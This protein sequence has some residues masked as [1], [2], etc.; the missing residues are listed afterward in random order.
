MPKTFIHWLLYAWLLLPNFALLFETP[1]NVWQGAGLL[2]I[3]IALV[4]LPAVVTGS[5]RT[6]YIINLPVALVSGFITG[7]IFFYHLPV[8]VGL[9]HSILDADFRESFEVVSRHIPATVLSVSGFIAYFLLSVKRGRE[10]ITHRG[11]FSAAALWCIVILV[12]YPYLNFNLHERFNTFFNISFINNSYPFNIA[13]TLTRSWLEREAN[14]DTKISLPAI[15][16]VQRDRNEIYVLVVGESARNETFQKEFRGSALSGRV[17]N[18]IYYDDVLSQANFTAL[19]IRLLLTGTEPREMPASGPDLIL[20]QKAA[21][22]YT[23][24]I[25]NN[26]SYDFNREAEL[27]DTEGNSGVTHYTRFDHDMLPIAASLIRNGNHRKLCLIL[28]MVGSHADYA[29]RYDSRFSKYPLIGTDIQQTRAA[30]NNTIVALMDFLNQLIRIINRDDCYAFLAYVSDHG[31]NLMEI[32]GL[33]EHVTMTPTNYELMVPMLFW[34]S[35]SFIDA[36]TARWKT[37]KDNRHAAVSN[38]YLMPTFLDAMGILHQVGVRQRLLPSLF[39]G[40]IPRPRYYV[41]PDMALHAERD[42]LR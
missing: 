16:T 24:V 4:N 12:Y 25:S 37:L 5:W 40:F 34:A 13:R 39:T 26:T 29:A 23:A 1:V 32:N 36:N 22:C 10:V 3:A 31:E 41:T 20:W 27:S 14:H 19:S 17:E 15:S 6:F 18:L 9:A 35:Q 42:M 21:G 2:I 30:Y 11:V 7:Y 38:V 28:H 8:T 33:K